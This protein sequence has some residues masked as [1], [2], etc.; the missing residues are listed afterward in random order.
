MVEL[1]EDSPPVELIPRLTTPKPFRPRLGYILWFLLTTQRP[2]TMGATLEPKANFIKAPHMGLHMVTQ[3]DN[4]EKE[5]A[6]AN[7]M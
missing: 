1:S 3:M 7:H 5:A 4:R 2:Q 6:L